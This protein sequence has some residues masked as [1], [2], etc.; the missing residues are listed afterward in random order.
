VVED[1]RE[2]ERALVLLMEKYAPHLEAGVDYRPVTPQE[3][4]RTAV[5]RLDIEAWS[6]K[7]K[8]EPPDFPG[9]YL[10]EDVRGD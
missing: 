6:G 1:H 8:T 4:R 10:L 7:E 2:A 5:I 3:V 9:A